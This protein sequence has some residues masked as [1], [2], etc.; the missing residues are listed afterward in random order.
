MQRT[1][2]RQ[3]QDM[4]HNVLASDHIGRLLMKLTVPMFFG[5]AVQAIYNVVDTIFIG[6]FVLNPEMAMAGLS[7]SFPFQML[8][9]G[10]G[11][12]V[13]LGGASLISR[14][15]GRGDKHGAE[16][17]LG[18]GIT[19]GV[20]LSLVLMLIFLPFINFWIRLIGAS[21]EVLPFARDYLTIMMAGAGFNVMSNALIG[22][23]RAEGNARVAMTAMIVASGLNIILDWI[24][25]VVLQMGVRGAALATMISMAVSTAYVLVYYISGSAYLKMRARNLLPNFSILK[26]I[27]VIGIASFVQTTAG[28]LSMMMIMRMAVAYGGD[29]AI[30]AFLIIQRVMWFSMMPSMV[31]GQGMQPVLGYNYGARRYHLVVRTIL[32][33]SVIA[34]G[35]GVLGFFVLYFFPEPI[36]RIF[37]GDELLI[38]KAAYI[39]KLVFLVLP[40][41]G[42]YQ[43]GSMVFPSVGKAMQTF[44]VAIA[45]PV[46]FMIPLLLLL[47][48]FFGERGVWFSF[49]GSD[50]LTFLLVLAL[51]IPLIR[52]L[53][54]TAAAAAGAA[55]PVGH[56]TGN[57]IR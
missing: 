47:P 36:F 16:H 1:P 7:I 55:E 13:G 44:I 56:G 31:I 3:N 34:I 48:R 29:I 37:T 32:I 17:T 21:D 20:A 43:V 8:T 45:R 50:I 26:Q 41:F 27:F 6:K 51:L 39:A 14:M 46:A 42:F 49:P 38:S 25:I 40:V 54:K 24:F 52:Q 28:S 18:N 9:M 30:A 23:V 22:F 19:F 53:K 2:D 10:V 12:M 4:A 5:M 33:A 15:I 35:V 11:Q 57:R